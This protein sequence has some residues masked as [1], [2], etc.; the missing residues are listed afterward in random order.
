MKSESL[1]LIEKKGR[2]YDL[3][4]KIQT[5]QAEVTALNQSI[6]RQTIVVKKEKPESKP[7][8]E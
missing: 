1:S 5:M 3:S 4:L 2:V 6:S 8:K 7:K